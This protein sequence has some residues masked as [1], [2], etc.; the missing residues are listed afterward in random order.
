MNA[1]MARLP[2]PEPDDSHPLDWYPESEDDPKGVPVEIVNRWVEGTLTRRESGKIEGASQV[3]EAPTRPYTTTPGKEIVM[4]LDDI[5]QAALD[6][7][8]RDIE[9]AF[10]SKPRPTTTVKP[11]RWG[12]RRSSNRAATDLP[13][14]AV[15]SLYFMQCTTCG[16]VK[17]GVSG[18]YRLRRIELEKRTGH[19]L[20]VLGFDYG[21]LEI[22]ARVHRY[23][24]PLRVTGEWYTPSEAILAYAQNLH[25]HPD[26]ARP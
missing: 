5:K 23:F 9:R 6:A 25:Y 3:L 17:I 13:W 7:A 19:T 14:L 12:V 4:P 10:A 20:R 24:S 26:E 18:D 1:E 15:P 8:V 21:D 2:L 11:V 16:L 22:E